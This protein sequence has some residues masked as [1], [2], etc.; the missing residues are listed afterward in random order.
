MQVVLCPS[1][2]AMLGAAVI[3]PQQPSATTRGSSTRLLYCL[4][5]LATSKTGLTAM[6]KSGN[7]HF[8]CFLDLYGIRHKFT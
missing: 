3:V 7:T 5:Q 2:T 1:S 8:K 4:L 6:I